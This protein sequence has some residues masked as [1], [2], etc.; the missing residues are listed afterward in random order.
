MKNPQAERP[1]IVGYATKKPLAAASF[2]LDGR[3]SWLCSERHAA[4][5]RRS[6]AGRVVDG[7]AHAR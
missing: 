3:Y 5:R 7:F 1:L 4:V 2:P 6:S